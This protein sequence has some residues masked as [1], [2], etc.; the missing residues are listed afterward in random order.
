MSFK[1]KGSSKG[2]FFFIKYDS[3]FKSPNL[4]KKIFQK[5]IL[6]LKYKT[7][8]I[9][10]LGQGGNFKFQ[11]QDSFLEYFFLG[12]LNNELHFLKKKHH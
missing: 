11:V 8:P 5:S 12:D 7:S 10:L 3:F 2:G 1:I 4:K 6:N 9:I